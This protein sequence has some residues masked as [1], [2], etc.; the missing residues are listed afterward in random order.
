MSVTCRWRGGA[1]TWKAKAVDD[2]LAAI[3][4]IV[5]EMGQACA[6]GH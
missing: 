6:V 2:H 4:T 3:S 1:R 5:V